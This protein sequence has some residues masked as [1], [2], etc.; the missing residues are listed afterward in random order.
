M[1]TNKSLGHAALEMICKNKLVRT[2]VVRASHL[3]FFNIYFSNYIEFETAPFQYKLFDLTQRT[4]WKLLVLVAFRN[5]GKTS[6][7]TTSHALWSVL[8]KHQCKY[9][10]IISQT[11]SQAKQQ[12][13]NIRNTLEKNSVLKND[14]G[15]MKTEDS[16]W[17]SSTIVFSKYDARITVASVNEAI[18]GTKH[19]EHRPDLVLIDD[20]EDLQSVKTRESRKKT[21]D[22]FK[23]E[24]IPIGSLRTRIVVI[25]NLLHEDC[26][27]MRLRKE[28]QSDILSGIYEEFPLVD[29]NKNIMWPG[30]FP[31]MEAVNAERKRIGDDRTWYRELLLKLLPEDDRVIERDWIQ[32]YDVLPPKTSAHSYRFSVSGVDL[33][34]KTNESSDYTAIVSGHVYGYGKD[35]KIY[36]TPSPVNRKMLFPAIIA[37]IKE[38]SARL[39]SGNRTRTYI[40]GNAAQSHTVQQLKSEGWPVIEV[41]SRGDKRERL[42]CVSPQ[43]QN[44]QVLFPRKGCELLIDQLANF[45]LED[46]DDLC[47]AFV[48][49]VS[50]VSKDAGKYQP[51]SHGPTPEPRSSLSRPITFGILKMN[52]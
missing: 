29:A 4:D 2:F 48:I 5:S 45:G 20:P 16:E 51:F 24:I 23:S 7:M 35:M 37:S 39:G 50:E 52:F 21:Y 8:G 26:L 31:T 10:L 6:I 34:A 3:W 14:L 42:F 49:L 46:H 13:M 30:K 27:V 15:P 28:I 41:I 32:Y 25:G 22:W 40:E 19:N 47:D 44:G 36:I 12:L 38:V 11:Q 43:I 18:R 17:G 1:K 33:A 9:V